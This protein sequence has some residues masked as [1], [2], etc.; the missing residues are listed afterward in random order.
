MIAARMPLL[1]KETVLLCAERAL[2]IFAIT[3][4]FDI[5]DHE[6]DK[7]MKL[8]TIPSLIGI[9]K[10]KALSIIMLL[11]FIGLCYLHYYSSINI[12]IAMVISVVSTALLILG[13][14]HRRHEYYFTGLLDSTIIL[15]FMLV[16]AAHKL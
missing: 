5:R 1:S 12:E 9:G 3:L 15:Q 2:F 13:T 16:L 11:I 14:H 4:P 10:A 6:S 8:T 7:R